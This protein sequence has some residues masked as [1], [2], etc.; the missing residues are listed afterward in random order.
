ME[1]NSLAQVKPSLWTQFKINFLGHNC[2]YV[3][4]NGRVGTLKYPPKFGYPETL[5]KDIRELEITNAET[6]DEESNPK[7]DLRVFKYL[8]KLTLG[9]GV[10][11]LTYNAIPASVEHL[12]ISDDL[13]LPQ[14]SFKINTLR[15]LSGPNFDI[16]LRYN[17]HHKNIYRD[18]HGRIHIDDNASYSN[19]AATHEENHYHKALKEICRNKRLQTASHILTNLE[20]SQTSGSVYIYA[21]PNSSEKDYS[22][23]IVVDTYPLPE[24][25]K[26]FPEEHLIGVFVNSV[27]DIDLRDFDKYPNL[28]RISVGKKVDTVRNVDEFTELCK[29]TEDGRVSIYDSVKTKRITVSLSSYQT[30]T[31]LSQSRYLNPKN[32]R[33]P[34]PVREEDEYSL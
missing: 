14:N 18:E 30:N 24:D 11:H 33:Q 27:S 23:H 22:T 17:T 31:S 16:N 34:E 19:E 3:D 5:C 9:K 1:E 7:D 15:Q 26:D 32:H 6:I 10:K 20:K 21:N 28:S 4:I 2:T 25:H 13:E 12:T 29:P 8:T